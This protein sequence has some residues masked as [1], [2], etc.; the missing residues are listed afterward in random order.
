[1]KHLFVSDWPRVIQQSER[2]HEEKMTVR[3]MYPQYHYKR[4]ILID[5]AF[6]VITTCVRSVPGHMAQA[7][8][9]VPD[10]R[11]F[12]QSNARRTEVA[13][14]KRLYAGSLIYAGV[15]LMGHGMALADTIDKTK[16]KVSQAAE[17]VTVTALKRE[18]SIQKTPVAITALSQAKLRNANVHDLA[19]LAK[20]V[21]GLVVTNA[22]PGQNQVSLRGIR[23][24]GDSQVGIYYDETALAA[25]PGS[26]S[27][28]AG[29]SSDFHLFDLQRV[30]VLRGPQ[31]TL[32]GAGAMGGAIKL[33]FNKPDSTRYAA[34]IDGQGGGVFHG[35]ATYNVNAML[36][37]P[38]IK[39]VLAARFVYYRSSMD[40]WINNPALGTQGVNEV[41]SEGGRFLLRFTPRRFISIDFATS[42][43]SQ[44]GGPSWWFPS[45]G[46]YNSRD[47]AR[48]GFNDRLS[49]YSLTTHIDMG[50]WVR[51]TH[52]ASYQNRNLLQTRDA[53]YLFNVVHAYYPNPALY[54]QP[55]S[56]EDVTNEFRFQSTKRSPLTWTVGGY[57]ENRRSGILSQA[58]ILTPNG[59]DP[60]SPTIGLSRTIGDIL[61]QQALFAEATYNPIRKL[62]LTA[63]M[64][65]YHYSKTV[66]GATSVGLPQLGTYPSANK[67]WGSE[68]AGFLY[69]VNL[70]YQFTDQILA[71]F[72]VSTGFRPGGVNQ[73][74]GLATAAPYLP[75]MLRT[76]EVGFKGS[77][78]NRR[79]TTN[80][81]AYRTDWSNMQVSLQTPTYA[82]LGN[83]GAARIQ[84]IE[85]EITARL[86]NELDL[87][88]NGMIQSAKLTADQI[89]NGSVPSVS[90]GH[91]GDRIPNIP[92]GTLTLALDYHHPLSRTLTGI[93]HVDGNYVSKSFSAFHP[94]ATSYWQIGDYV[95]FNARVGVRAHDWDVYTVVNNL[96][97]QR[98]ITTA[99]SPISSSLE[100]VVTMPPR[101]IGLNVSKTF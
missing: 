14:F 89:A 19:D 64:R 31:G 71:Y 82:Y 76:Y 46:L 8:A 80:L 39:D 65:Y 48:L 79:L 17:E 66:S 67:S 59:I 56:L 62:S 12:W 95:V 61:Q 54:Y 51:F 74:I 6:D 60:A 2:S 23:S 96:T 90:T 83:A 85:A 24:A 88:F 72:Q 18:T 100:T 87:S 1:M 16:P 26:T 91:T 33:I 63:G 84:G 47:K 92:D 40:G 93:V 37:V 53:S 86:T 44:D 22:G 4:F 3:K 42:Q 7:V 13:G 41:H 35:G 77:F 55:Q 5:F 57:L 78:L 49:V 28:P 68:N 98:A 94:G 99:S 81:A 50:Q 43:S 27:N 75:D 15:S 11:R 10:T 30:E 29:S 21:P 69:K 32:Y 97:D 45:A 38:L 58:H 9:F 25:P 52:V 73:G 34:A 70:A 20:L 36:N 101:M